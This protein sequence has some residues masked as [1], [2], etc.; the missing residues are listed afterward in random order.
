MFVCTVIGKKIFCILRL[1]GA[2]F[3]AATLNESCYSL[4]GVQENRIHIHGRE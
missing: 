2:K 1:E 4:A 3:G